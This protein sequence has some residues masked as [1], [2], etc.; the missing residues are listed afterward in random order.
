MGVLTGRDVIC[1]IVITGSL[2]ASRVRR[3]AG[4]PGQRQGCTSGATA[5]IPGRDASSLQQGG[6]REGREKDKNDY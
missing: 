2:L 1:L 6:S 4:R 3:D 5:T